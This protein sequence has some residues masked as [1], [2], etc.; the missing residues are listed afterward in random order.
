M[1]SEM[2]ET[3]VIPSGDIHSPYDYYPIRFTVTDKP[4]FFTPWQSFR[5]AMQAAWGTWTFLRNQRR[6]V[7]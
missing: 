2:R 6:G 5:L 7:R 1:M 4:I 3:L